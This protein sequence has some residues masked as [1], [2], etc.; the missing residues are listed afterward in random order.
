[1][2]K[3]FLGK[4][5]ARVL[6][7]AHARE[8][9]FSDLSGREDVW[10][11]FL[12]DGGDGF[13][14]TYTISRLLAQPH[15]SVEVPND[16]ALRAQARDALVSADGV[17]RPRIATEVDELVPLSR[18]TI[19]S[20][21]SFDSVR[22]DSPVSVKGRDV[23]FHGGDVAYPS[24]SNEEYVSRFIRP[25]E[26]ALPRINSEDNVKDSVEQ[27]QMFIIPGN[28]D[29]H[30]GLETFLHWIVYN[31]KV[32]G[33]K[34]PQKHSYFAVKLSH[35]WWV[36]GLDLGLS[37]DLDRP[38][39]EYFCALLETGKV[40]ADDRVVVLT[41]RPNWVFDPAVAEVSIFP[42]V[43][44]LRSLQRT[45]Y[46][47][48]V[49]LEKIGEPRLAMRLAGDLHHYTRYMPGNGSNGPPLVTSGGAGA[50]LHPTHYPP[51]D[52]LNAA[53]MAS[54]LGEQSRDGNA[55]AAAGVGLD[56]PQYISKASG[57]G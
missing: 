46:T 16:R 9:T 48:N 33:W 23:V 12:A 51:K 20:L 42:L 45:G 28:H 25:L 37:Y 55:H 29:W 18:K 13:D 56:L 40:E 50:F 44:E 19:R 14:S 2:M 11:D 17:A 15:L 22:D 5:D 57:I 1:M 3:V 34:L 30:D 24:P 41:H 4:F 26:W 10:L 39:Y 36:W 7:S 43:C 27:P 8:I 54:R 52:F 31:Q 38:Q 32:A 6:H 47:L 35:G 49:L 21:P 53:N